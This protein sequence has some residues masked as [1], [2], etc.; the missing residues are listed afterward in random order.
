LESFRASRKCRKKFPSPVPTRVAVI[1]SF[2]KELLAKAPA[3]DCRMQ[4]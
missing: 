2:S 4:K 3:I 1:A